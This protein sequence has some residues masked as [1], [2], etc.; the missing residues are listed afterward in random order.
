M[1]YQQYVGKGETVLQKKYQEQLF[2]QRNPTYGVWQENRELS[3]L[4][5]QIRLAEANLKALEKPPTNQAEAVVKL[6]VGVASLAWL[7]YVLYKK[8]TDKE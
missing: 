7:G 2:R 8:H 3:N 1:D 4:N 5:F 6:V